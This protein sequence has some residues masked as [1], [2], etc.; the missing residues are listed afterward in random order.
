VMYNGWSDMAV[1]AF[2]TIGYFESI[3]AHDATASEDARLFLMP[4][5]DHCN[6]GVG[7]SVVNYL[8]VIDEWVTMGEAPDEVPAYWLDENRQL[9]GSRLLC[10]YP[11]V[12]NYDGQGD[13]RDASSFS[14][15][16]GE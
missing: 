9:A 8:N 2:G 7:P 11:Q 3:L 12:A 16:G 13:H 4:G 14:C 5:M 15:V 6:G 10:A 1:T